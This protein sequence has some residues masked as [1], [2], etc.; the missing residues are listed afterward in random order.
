ML[1]VSS[2]TWPAGL[3]SGKKKALQGKSYVF[4]PSCGVQCG[5]QYAENDDAECDAGLFFWYTL[6]VA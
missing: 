5:V 1:E 4:L 6:L 2:A 3:K